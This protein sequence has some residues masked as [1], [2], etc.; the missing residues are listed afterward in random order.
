MPNPNST[1]IVIG[2]AVIETPTASG[3]QIGFGTAIIETVSTPRRSPARR[4][5]AAGFNPFWEDSPAQW[6]TVVLQGVNLPGIATV[7]GMLGRKLDV[8]SPPGSDGAT[9]RDKGYEPAKIVITLRLWAR[10]Q[11]DALD[12]AVDIVEGAVTVDE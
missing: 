6:D 8:L 3:I 2:N 10:E 9:I 1:N 11:F 7:D 4:A 12:Q 5:I